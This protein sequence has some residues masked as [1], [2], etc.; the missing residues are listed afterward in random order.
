MKT[1]NIIKGIIC[2]A[3]AAVIILA[4]AGYL[5]FAIFAGMST[6]SLVASII[7]A[8]IFVGAIID[9]ELDGIIIF[10]GV[11]LKLLE[12]PLGLQIK[13]PVLIA[14]IVLLL[15][16]RH[17]LLPDR[18]SRLTVMTD[19]AGNCMYKEIDSRSREVNVSEED[20]SYVYAKNRFSGIVKYINSFN[21]Q[22]AQIDSRFG[23]VELY[24]NDAK[25][26]SGHAE[27]ELD[28]KFSGVEIYVPRNWTIVN[29]LHCKMGEI[30]VERMLLEGEESPVE[31]VISGYTEFGGVEVK[32]I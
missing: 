8:V 19:E 21:F 24:F 9:R 3:V 32:R 28:T 10:G 1:K 25:V 20:G 22:K 15:M 4:S 2:L 12:T 29:N 26:P 6:L 23:G 11:L 17:F 13:I 16:A 27:L 7:V 14:V 18:K 30:Q 31:L 5:N